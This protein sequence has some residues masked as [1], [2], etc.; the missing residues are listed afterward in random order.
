M[1]Y[2]LDLSPEGISQVYETCRQDNDIV[3]A[4]YVKKEQNIPDNYRC[5]LSEEL[6]PPSYRKSVQKLIQEGK[7]SRG[8]VFDMGD[9]FNARQIL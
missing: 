4:F 2:H 8:E 1:L 9:S 6:Q 3:R 5:S 7:K